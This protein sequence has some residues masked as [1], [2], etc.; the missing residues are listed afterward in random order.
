M[1][2]PITT[3]KQAQLLTTLTDAENNHNNNSSTTTT[4]TN[5]TPQNEEIIKYKPIE[6]TPFTL[7]WQ[8]DM[9]Y[10]LTMGKFKITENYE[11]EEEI[12]QILTEKPYQ[13]IL[14]MIGVLI[15]INE[16]LKEIE[17]IEKI[18]KTK[19]QINKHNGL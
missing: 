13:L 1:K 4:T 9:G 12:E 14:E 11:T 7:V 6:K 8:K 16:E 15:E 19:E 2:Q 3:S 10:F 17:T 18:N 5:S